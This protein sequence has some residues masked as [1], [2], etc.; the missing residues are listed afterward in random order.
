MTRPQL[1][2]IFGLLLLLI[3]LIFSLNFYFLNRLNDQMLKDRE[4]NVKVESHIHKY[5]KHPKPT[6]ANGNPR[7]YA[8]RN[9]MLRNMQLANYENVSVLWE[10][11]HWVS[12]LQLLFVFIIVVHT[13]KNRLQY[14]CII[15]NLFIFI[16]A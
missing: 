9:K 16:V 13:S 8:I 4:T 3:L 11:S 7:F 15:N 6:Y 12:V 10:F 5:A 1:C 2:T 14:V